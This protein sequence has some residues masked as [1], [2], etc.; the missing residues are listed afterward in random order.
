V[1]CEAHLTHLPPSACANRFFGV[2]RGFGRIV[3]EIEVSNLLVSLHVRSHSRGSLGL[4]HPLRSGTFYA[5]ILLLSA[6]RLCAS[7]IYPFSSS[8]SS[9]SEYLLLA[10]ARASCTGSSGRFSANR[11]VR[12][13]L[14]SLS[15]STPPRTIDGE[16]L[17]AAGR[18]CAFA[19]SCHTCAPHPRPEVT[20]GPAILRRLP[21]AEAPGLGRGR[22]T[23]CRSSSSSSAG[24]VAAAAAAPG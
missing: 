17:G 22:G 3:S 10:R 12:R 4:S 8:L 7:C 21:P 24:V 23:T 2:C 11:A 13:R 18:R 9:L 5:S 19:A 16:A 15:S 6:V 20:S 14:A 1:L